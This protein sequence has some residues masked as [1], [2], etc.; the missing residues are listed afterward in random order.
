MFWER[1]R[2]PTEAAKLTRAHRSI[3]HIMRWFD[4]WTNLA[5]SPI[6][7]IHLFRPSPSLFLPSSPLPLTPLLPFSVPLVLFLSQSSHCCIICQKKFGCVPSS[8]YARGKL[9]KAQ[10][11]YQQPLPTTPARQ[12]CCRRL[13]LLNE[14]LCSWNSMV[15][16]QNPL[17]LVSRAPKTAAGEIRPE[18]RWRVMSAK[19]RGTRGDLKAMVEKAMAPHS[20]TLAWKI[21][22]MEEPGGIQSMG[23]LSWTR[24]S[25]FTFTFHFHALEKEMATHSSV[26][27]LRIPG[28]GEPGGLP[29]MGS[30]SQTQLKQLSSSSSRETSKL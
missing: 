10:R 29:S 30:Q 20:N 7:H 9:R 11:R 13:G 15:G 24:L 26:L 3:L 1:L 19:L 28:T 8:I 18:P 16:E 25:D 5:Y 17:P 6:L 22:W 2:T 21:P 4:L 27:A 23:S 12:D 14:N